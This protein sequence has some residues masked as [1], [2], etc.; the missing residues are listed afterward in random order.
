MRGNAHS[1]LREWRSAVADYRECVRTAWDCMTSFDL[2]Y[3]LWNL[4][5]ALAHLH[6]PE[7]ALRLAASADLFW[8][9]RF[10]SLSTEDQR[11]LQRIRR[12]AARQIDQRRVEALWNEG[13]ALPVAQAVALALKS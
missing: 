5:R 3:G 7:D 1:G 2:A 8:R 4:P 11:Y 9:T 10:G 6:Q 12:L 13:A